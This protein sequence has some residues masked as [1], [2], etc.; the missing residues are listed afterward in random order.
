ML[1]QDLIIPEVHMTMKKAVPSLSNTRIRPIEPEDFPFIRSL[2]AEFPTFTVPSEYLLWFFSRFHPEYCRVIEH[3]SGDLGA[4]I[5]G[6]P[7]S[8]PISGIAIWQVASAKGDNALVLEFF[9]AYLSDLVKQTEAKSVFFTMAKESSSLRLIRSLAK[10]FGGSE[11]VQVD[12]VPTGQDECEFQIS[13]GSFHT[14][15]PNVR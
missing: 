2:A 13:I 10:Q 3:E 14:D 8:T 5:L 4:Y 6:M 1:F 12:S 9:A 15:H 7:T 11:L